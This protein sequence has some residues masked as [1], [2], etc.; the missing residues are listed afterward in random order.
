MK[1]TLLLTQRCCL[2][3]PTFPSDIHQVNLQLTFEY[4]KTQ[5]PWKLADFP[6]QYMPMLPGYSPPEFALGI[7]IELEDYVQYAKKAN[8]YCEGTTA[9][10]FETL[11]Q[12][13]MTCSTFVSLHK[14]Y[15]SEKPYALTLGSNY[16]VGKIPI[17]ECIRLK[18]ALAKAGIQQAQIAWYLL[19]KESDEPDDWGRNRDWTWDYLHAVNSRRARK[20]HMVEQGRSV[21]DKTAR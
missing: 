2:T 21:N 13:G 5:G 17:K 20:G 1:E 16:T 19:D 8:L 18:A 4:M 7:G 3:P 14:V 9:W 11:R 10:G 6:V 15:G 12:L